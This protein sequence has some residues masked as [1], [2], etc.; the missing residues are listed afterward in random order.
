MIERAEYRERQK[1]FAH[2][3]AAGGI[4]R[5]PGCLTGRIDLRSPRPR[6]LP[7]GPLPALLL[8]PRLPGLFSGRAHTAAVISSA[9]EIVLCVSVPEFDP[10]VIVADDIRVS[11]DFTATI[12]GALA[13]LG[14]DAAR[15]CFV[16]ADVLPARY[17]S[18]ACRPLPTGSVR[19][20][21]RDTRAPV[22]RE[23]R[24]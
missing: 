22:A 1:R 6:P 19:R 11:D 3:L 14:L 16:G 15:L 10:D 9:G 17:W 20:G 2:A 12:A 5:R 4:R 8:P 7:H 23:E 21:R 13:S 18:S 24:R